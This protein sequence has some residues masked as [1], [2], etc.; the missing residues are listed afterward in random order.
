MMM[1]M[2]GSRSGELGGEV[3]VVVVVVVPLRSLVGGRGFAQT[4]SKGM[5]VSWVRLKDLV[6]I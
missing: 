6:L 4:A 3:M 1:M 5:R 2:R